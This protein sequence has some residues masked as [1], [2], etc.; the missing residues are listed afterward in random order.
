MMLLLH[1]A[2]V[3]LAPRGMSKTVLSAA[4]TTAL[5][6]PARSF[7]LMMIMLLVLDGSAI[8]KNCTDLFSRERVCVCN[9]WRKAEE[10]EEG[11]I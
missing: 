3:C 6:D 7:P 10:R 9:S 1:R 5:R 11:N 8:A 2:R 4:T